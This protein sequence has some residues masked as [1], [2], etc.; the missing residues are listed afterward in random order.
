MKDAQ[1]KESLSRVRDVVS[2]IVDELS[3]RSL[4][5]DVQLDGG[6]WMH[7]WRVICA[8]DK[9]LGVIGTC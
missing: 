8:G 2:S 4:G 1:D 5:W 6:C 3:L 9:R 7:L